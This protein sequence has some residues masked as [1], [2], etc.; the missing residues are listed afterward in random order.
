MACLSPSAI[1]TSSDIGNKA[2]E[3]CFSLDLN[4][5]CQN[6]SFLKTFVDMYLYLDGVSSG[7]AERKGDRGTEVS[8]KL[9]AGSPMG[10]SGLELTEP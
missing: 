3:G 1:I 8:S 10:G 7:G 2:S 4:F 5:S 9:T 6:P